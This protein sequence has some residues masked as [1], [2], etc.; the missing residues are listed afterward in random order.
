MSAFLEYIKQLNYYAEVS[1]LAEV[2]YAIT[3]P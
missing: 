2:F 1:E 3:I